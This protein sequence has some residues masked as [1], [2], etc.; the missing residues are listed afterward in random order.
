MHK[1]LN[2]QPVNGLLAYA[3]GVST[4]DGGNGDPEIRR[5]E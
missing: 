1:D 5:N 2:F 3:S 4:I